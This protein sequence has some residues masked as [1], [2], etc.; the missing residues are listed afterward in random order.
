MS[1][2][3]AKTE[4]MGTPDDHILRSRERERPAR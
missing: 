4:L 3:G 1:I 2:D